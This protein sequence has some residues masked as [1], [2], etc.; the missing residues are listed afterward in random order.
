MVQ[1]IF[2]PSEQAFFFADFIEKG[3]K[4]SQQQERDADANIGNYSDIRDL[5]HTL[6]SHDQNLNLKTTK[7]FSFKYESLMQ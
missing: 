3:D 2:V 1:L 7:P 6:R 4:K 5:L